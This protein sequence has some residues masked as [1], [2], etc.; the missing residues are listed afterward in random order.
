MALEMRDGSIRPPRKVD[1]F[2]QQIQGYV[3]QTYPNT[4]RFRRDRDIK[5]CAYFS[6]TTQPPVDEMKKCDNSDL[7]MGSAVGVA[8][9][10]VTVEYRDGCTG[11][12]RENSRDVVAAI[13]STAENANASSHTG[14]VD[15]GRWSAVGGCHGNHNYHENYWGPDHHLGEGFEGG[16]RIMPG[17][18]GFVFPE[19]EADGAQGAGGQPK[20]PTLLTRSEARPDP[21]NLLV[22]FRFD[23][24]AASPATLDL[25]E[26]SLASD[27]SRIRGKPLAAL[28]HGMAYYHRRGYWS[29]PANLLNPFWHAS[30]VRSN[31]DASR[32]EQNDRTAED[33]REANFDTAAEV[34]ERFE[35]LGNNFAGWQ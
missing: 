31:I 3:N 2:L 12:W 21:W 13:R 18:L 22:R 1:Q 24:G 35:S 8:V 23:R 14:S 16:H 19:N 4:F 34:Y 29:E 20:L 30:L 27:A 10:R 28:S 11:R 17:G 25:G 32:R 33:L 9:G 5:G 7:G 26:D 15:F 6:G